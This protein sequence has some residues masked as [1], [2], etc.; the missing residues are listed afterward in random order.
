MRQFL[1]VAMRYWSGETS[2]KPGM[3]SRCTRI[4]SSSARIVCQLSVKLLR[5][6]KWLVVQNWRVA[7]QRLPAEE[8]AERARKPFAGPLDAPPA[9]LFE[10]L[11]PA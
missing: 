2:W 1:P 3:A 11:G 8:I 7:Y 4:F 6:G 10:S 9:L 5:N